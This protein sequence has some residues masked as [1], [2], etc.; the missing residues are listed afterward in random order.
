MTRITSSLLP[1]WCLGLLVFVFHLPTTH[2]Y[3]LKVQQLTPLELLEQAQLVVAV[4][5]VPGTAPWEAFVLKVIKSP[6]GK[7]VPQQLR[8]TVFSRT[9]K[10]NPS[11]VANQSQLIF[12]TS[13]GSGIYQCLS[14]GKQAV[15]PKTQLEWP[16]LE[17]HISTFDAAFDA[18]SS[19]QAVLEEDVAAQDKHLSDALKRGNPLLR[20]L[21]AE[22]LSKHPDASF[23]QS[24]EVI[25][26]T[27]QS[28]ED[29][30]REPIVT[31]ESTSLPT[32]PPPLIQPAAPKKVPEA[33]PTTSTPTEETTSST[34]WS[35]IVVLIVAGCGLLW[36][37]LKR[38]T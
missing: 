28:N 29:K 4:N 33:K 1:S 26:K 16:Y 30:A 15:W 18:F 27:I 13:D 35:L 19:M 20:S 32:L 14:Y 5:V 38:R 3:A 21:A 23:L 11:F 22:F 2:A 6:P 36:L 25:A 10:D 31:E 9:A 12:L 37:L 7:V 24:R 17:Q 8:F 34:P